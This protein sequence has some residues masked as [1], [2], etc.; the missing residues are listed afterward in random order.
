MQFDVTP[1]VARAVQSARDWTRTLG[2][3]E[4]RP[5]HLFL[6]LLDEPEGRVAELLAQTGAVA[7]RVRQS[8]L[9]AEWP[10][11]P[12]VPDLDR[13]LSAA[14]LLAL[15][16]TGERTIA[17]EHILAAILQE[18][19]FVRRVLEAAGVDTATVEAAAVP[20]AGPP[21]RLDEPL[22]LSEAFERL[23][24]ARILDA[25]AN[26][27]REALRVIEDYARFALDDAF[28][29]REVKTLR[30]DLAEAMD[31]AGRLPLLEAR[32][33]L[34]DV[35]TKIGIPSESNRDSSRHVVQVNLK[36]LQEALR[37]LEEFG[38]LIRPELG[39]ALEQI[40]YRSYTLERALILGTDARERLRSSRLYLLVTGSTAVTS[41]E[42]LISEAAAGGVDI[43]QLREKNLSDREL[44]DRARRVRLLTR[45]AGIPFIVNDRPDIARLCDA[46]GVHLGQEDMPIREARRVV[47]PDA[48]IGVSTHNPDQVRQ[49]IRDGAGY[50]GIGPV[51]ASPTKSFDSL[52]G[53]EFVRQAI[54]ETS[55]PAFA[56]GGITAEN[57]SQIVAAGATCIAV[58]SAVCG[59]NAPRAAA[60]ALR[61]YL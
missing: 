33:T 9:G 42:F 13:I 29:C 44:L 38:K 32:D 12:D 52:P 7:D 2:A 23:D 54:A 57:V 35:G 39:A 18:D 6:A 3:I 46:D 15:E 48:L 1:A 22:D 20:A 17:S 53:L 50:I 56:L 59:S 24:T 16:R 30:H 14:R 45:Q 36:R 55:L 5:L 49:A 21:L 19:T 26:R 43:V 4:T 61:R 37:S 25:A 41:L 27:A 31:S 51:F 47:G 60:R 40:R 11:S 58:S 8:L 34:A 10:I 28:L